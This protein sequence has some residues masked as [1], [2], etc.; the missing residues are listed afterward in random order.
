MR[1]AVISVLIIVFVSL[2]AFMVFATIIKARGNRIRRE[3]ISHLPYFSFATLDNR[4]FSSSEIKNEPVL[5][6]RFHPEC[7]HC[8]YEITDLLNSDIPD[9]GVSI[10]L[11]SSAPPDTVRKFLDQ[12]RLNDYPSVIPLLDTAWIFGDVF[13]YNSVPTNLIYDN[14]HDLIKVFAGEVKTETLM[15]YLS[16]S[17][18]DR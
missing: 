6:V 7:E 15:K 5:I 4:S 2:A 11:I 13:G 9:S 3:K 10:I 14:R 12:F 16:V 1:K 18:Q 8:Q 17:E